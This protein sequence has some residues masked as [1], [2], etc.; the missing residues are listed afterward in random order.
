M[1]DEIKALGFE[2]I[3]LGFALSKKVVDEILPLVE[4]GLIKV[5]SLHNICPTPAC[6]E[7]DEAS[8]D[9]YSLASNLEDERALAIDTARNTILYAE[10]LGAKA[11]ILHTGKLPIKDRMKELSGAFENRAEY[12]RIR[13]EMES[14]RAGRIDGYLDNVVRSLSVLAPCARRSG[15]KLAIE[16]RYSYRDIP[17]AEEFDYIFDKVKDVWYWHDVGHAEVFD[18]LGLSSHTALLDRCA[19]RLIGIHLH[20]ITG[21]LYDHQAP[22]C[23]T[24]DFGKVSP[25]LKTDTIKVIEAH[26]PATAKQVARG[27][28]YLKTILGD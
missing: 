16:T 8:P 19:G 9:Y 4:K 23:G 3:E 13:A 12:K 11:V 2:S 15:V 10:K 20:D 21:F 24:F 14:D 1:I 18:R 7:I 27:L 22:L 25:Y 6:I 5:S 17:L 26:Q 28:K